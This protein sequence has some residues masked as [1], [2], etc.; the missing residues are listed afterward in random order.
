M[1]LTRVAMLSIAGMALTSLT[2]YGVTDPVALAAPASDGVSQA[3][4]EL[5]SSERLAPGGFARFVND[6]TLA[7]EARLGHAKVQ[8]G[9]HRTFVTVEVRGTDQQATQ[10]PPLHMSLVI[11]KS[12]SMKGDRIENARNAARGVVDRLADGDTVSVVSFDTGTRVVVT[13]TVLSSTTRPRIREAISSITLGGD[14]C[15]SCGIETAMNEIRRAATSQQM[16]RVIVLSDGAANN[17]IRDVAGFQQLA[18]TCRGMNIAV[19]TVGLG[20]DYNEQVLSALALE[21]NGLHHFVEDGASLARVFDAETNTAI[22]TVANGVEAQFALAPGARLIRVFGRAF[23]RE[24]GRVVVPLGTFSPNQVKTVLLEVEISPTEVG[25]RNV[26]DVWVNYADLVKDGAVTAHGALATTVGNETEGL[27]PFVAARVSQARNAESLKVANDLA[28]RGD[29]AAA[30]LELQSRLGTLRK[31]ATIANN[32]AKGKGDSR[33]GDIDKNFK[34]QIDFADEAIQDF[35]K[36]SP[37]PKAAKRAVRKNQERI[38]EE[39]L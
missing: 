11:D 4:A 18:R 23:R 21:S 10:R 36:P 13:P 38:F 20:I 7:V 14:T 32:R 17:G 2:V 15:I 9:T 27:D 24:A 1:K 33:G 39:S 8:T 22:N 25:T 35:A 6:G 37:K 28:K 26:A 16:H 34:Q 5:T 30:K 12:G 31:T 29:F 3:I 19:S